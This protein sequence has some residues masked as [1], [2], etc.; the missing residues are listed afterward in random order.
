[1]KNRAIQEM[2]AIQYTCNPD[3]IEVEYLA[4]VPDVDRV[5]S[6]A[7]FKVSVDVGG[8]IEMFI[9]SCNIKPYES[10]EYTL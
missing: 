6:N 9:F 2:F 7:E 5:S 3:A 8:K 1:M 10:S 4:T